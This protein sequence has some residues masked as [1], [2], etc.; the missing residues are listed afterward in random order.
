MNLKTINNKNLGAALI[1]TLI[2]IPFLLTII[3]LTVAFMDFVRNYSLVSQTIRE[4]AQIGAMFTNNNV[5][6][7]Y[8]TCI[9]NKRYQGGCESGYV[10]SQGFETAYPKPNCNLKSNYDTR[11]AHITVLNKMRFY[12]ASSSVSQQ[13]LEANLTT[14]IVQIDEDVILKAKLNGRHES[15]F[16][17]FGARNLEVESFA[18][19]RADEIPSP[20]PTI[21]P[22]TEPTTEPSNSLEDEERP[23]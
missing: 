10:T 20:D 8:E 4:S 22:T 17:I 2:V 18:F 9:L 14:E 19:I 1:E 5:P 21:Q 7:K 12:I 23:F 6:S 15:L 13:L 3:F 16:T 11:C